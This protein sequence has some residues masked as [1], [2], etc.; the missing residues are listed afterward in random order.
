MQARRQ[1]LLAQIANTI[2]YE[3]L[4]WQ[5]SMGGKGGWGG[6]GIGVARAAV[7]EQDEDTCEMLMKDPLDPAVTMR[8]TLLVSGKLF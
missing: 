7:R 2:D 1:L 4:V 3:C 8:T 6:E 5:H